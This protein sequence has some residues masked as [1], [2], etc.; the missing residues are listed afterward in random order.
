MLSEQY[1]GG[2]QRVP[3]SGA[4]VETCWVPPIWRER[5]SLRADRAKS[6]PNRQRSSIAIRSSEARLWFAVPIARRACRRLDRASPR[7]GPG[8]RTTSRRCD[9]RGKNSRCVLERNRALHEGRRCRCSRHGK[10]D[11][12]LNSLLFCGV[13]HGCRL[14]RT[15]DGCSSVGSR[16]GVCRGCKEFRESDD[17][18]C[19]PAFG[20]AKASVRGRHPF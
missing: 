3:I 15:A 17:G 5:E 18:R 1:E 7:T 13:W 6:K 8:Q 10:S 9:H 12:I 14:T 19:T 11:G 4:D 20:R 2:E 16:S